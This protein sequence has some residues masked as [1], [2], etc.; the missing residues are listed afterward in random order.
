MNKPYRI[1]ICGPGATGGG[2]IRGILSNPA[3]ELVGVR[4]Y[5]AAKHGRDV[6]ELVGVEPVGVMAM[7]DLNDLLKL[8]TDC[9]FYMSQTYSDSGQTEEQLALLEA[10]HN[11]IG[12]GQYQALD[13]VDKALHQRFIAATT[14]GK[15]TFHACGIDPEFFSERLPLL[16][17]ALQYDVTR[18]ELWEISPSDTIGEE[19]LK[20]AGFGK[21]MSEAYGNDFVMRLGRSLLVPAMC[22]LSAHMGYPIDRVEMTPQHVAAPFDIDIGRAKAPKGTLA[23]ISRRY[24]CFSGD[25]LFYTHND[26]YYLS[27]LG[28]PEGVTNPDCYLLRVEGTPSYELT[29]SFKTS[30]LRDQLYD[31][32]HKLKPAFMAVGAL[33]LNAVPA[34]VAAPPGIYEYPLPAAW[35]G[36]AKV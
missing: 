1:A 35:R 27:P 7:T 22:R 11:V 12:V 13:L 4:A 6:G 10:G 19:S 17:S 3:F 18:I 21:S 36:A 28:P 29:L 5:S 24:E 15:S 16:M 31:E 25:H 32:K 20:S 8:D 34:V 26:Y 30:I 9:V 2:A 33:A 23:G 14:K